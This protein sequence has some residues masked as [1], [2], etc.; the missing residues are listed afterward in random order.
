[1]H[2]SKS[3]ATEDCNIKKECDKLINE[4]KNPTSSSSPTA[5]VGR[6]RHLTE[7]DEEHVSEDSSDVLLDPPSNDTNE[8]DLH[9]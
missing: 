7:D 5:T 2:F 3:H 1:M 6:L 8:V 4:K 9:A